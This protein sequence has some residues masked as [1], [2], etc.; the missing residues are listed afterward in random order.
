M[1][2]SMLVS[3]HQCLAAH[4]PGRSSAV[5]RWAAR[6]AAPGSCSAPL[7]CRC[8]WCGGCHGRGERNFCGRPPET[9]MVV[10]VM[11]NVL[12]LLKAK[13]SNGLSG[14]AV[15]SGSRL[16]PNQTTFTGL[17]GNSRTLFLFVSYRN[18]ALPVPLRFSK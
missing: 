15:P 7:R 16:K 18:I 4:S 13:E 12:H 5:P 8:D 10:M 6:W 14:P 2:S 1:R 17:G 3:T 9:R 11:A